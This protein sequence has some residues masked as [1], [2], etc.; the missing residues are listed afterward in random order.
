VL[1]ALTIISAAA[2]VISAL[3]SLGLLPQRRRAQPQTVVIVVTSIE[4]LVIEPQPT[5][6]NES[7]PELESAA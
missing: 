3:D 7:D 5:A 6:P 4:A 2:A 1:L